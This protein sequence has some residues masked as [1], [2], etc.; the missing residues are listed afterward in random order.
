MYAASQL[1]EDVL[2]SY[3]SLT[4][5]ST[6]AVYD[7][8]QTSSFDH[9]DGSREFLTTWAVIGSCPTKAPFEYPCQPDL[10]IWDRWYAIDEVSQGHLWE[11]FLYLALLIASQPPHTP[12]V[13]ADRSSM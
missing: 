2:A 3:A 13:A 12:M 5:T 7:S 11:S 1:P 8:S 6:F 9:T 10:D 4:T